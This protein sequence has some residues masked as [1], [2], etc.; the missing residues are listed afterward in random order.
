MLN[1]L[2]LS[3]SVWVLAGWFNSTILAQTPLQEYWFSLAS[4]FLLNCSAWPFILNFWLSLFSDF[5]CLCCCTELRELRKELSSAALTT[6][7]LTDYS[8][9]V[10][11]LGSPTTHILLSQMQLIW[12]CIF[13]FCNTTKETK[14]NK[15][16]PVN[17]ARIYLFIYSFCLICTKKFPRLI[18]NAFAGQKRKDYHPS[19]LL[20]QNTTSF[21]PSDSESL[22]TR[23]FYYKY[24]F[25][26]L[27][28][29]SHPLVMPYF[30]LGN[31]HLNLGRIIWF[32]N[33]RH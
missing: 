20:T 4:L 32:I 29:L 22:I 21:H 19:S 17:W 15:T 9:V 25:T 13:D 5:S 2:I 10:L 24:S 6:S 8:K 27:S 26:I 23:G 11:A 30:I 7:W 3:S 12:G 31:I 18:L 16:V 28:F 14:Q 1:K 33:I